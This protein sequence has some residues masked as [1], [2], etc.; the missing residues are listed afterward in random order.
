MSRLQRSVSSRERQPY[1]NGGAHSTLDGAQFGVFEVNFRNGELRRNGVRVKLPEKPFQILEALLEKAG[2]MV[3]REELRK[4]L[5]PHT[6]VAFDR[7]INTAVTQLRRAL[8][9]PAN[10]PHFIETRYRLGYRFVAPVRTRNGP[11]PSTHQVRA[12]IDALA[13]LSFDRSSGDSK[14]E[15]VSDRITE[16]IIT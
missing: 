4:K 9:D 8:G 7:S 13:V 11:E 14:T 5:W 2:D 15:V 3:R 1:P 12:T 16:N 10:Q 6:H